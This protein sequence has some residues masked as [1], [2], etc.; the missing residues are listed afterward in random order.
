MTGVTVTK[1]EEPARQ[2]TQGYTHLK[3][4]ETSLIIQAKIEG[5]T[6]NQVIVRDSL[7]EDGTMNHDDSTQA[8][9]DSSTASPDP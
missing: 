5:L 9:I 3:P 1:A 7:I 2:P 6:P 4:S 8:V